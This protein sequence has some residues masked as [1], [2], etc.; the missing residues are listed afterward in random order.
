MPLDALGGTL[1]QGE[2]CCTTVE[3]GGRGRMGGGFV[4]FSIHCIAQH[5]PP[6][7]TWKHTRA[8]VEKS[9]ILPLRL[10]YAL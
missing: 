4:V 8:G 7:G 3:A 1:P 10:A 6:G 2:T 9:T 5:R